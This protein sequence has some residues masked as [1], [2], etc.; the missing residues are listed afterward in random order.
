MEHGSWRR[1]GSG[2]ICD[3]TRLGYHHV[4]GCQETVSEVITIF[5]E[6]D[7]FE[8]LTRTDEFLDSACDTY[9]CIAGIMAGV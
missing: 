7:N 1:T 6:G 4:V 2:I 3:E 8:V 5:V 9:V